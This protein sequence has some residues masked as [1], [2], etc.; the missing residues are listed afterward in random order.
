M[1][2]LI[3]GGGTMGRCIAAALPEH[4]IT[5]IEK[6]QD[7]CDRIM[8]ELNINVVNGD[9][10]KLYILKKAN[11][12]SADAVMAVTNN[13]DVNLF[14]SL[15]AIKRGKQAVARVHEPEYIPIFNELGIENIVS[16]EQRAA[17]DIAKKL[18][19]E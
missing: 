6:N 4:E 11:F 2:I 17:M 9:A 3:V 14:I 16:P 19:W 7:K 10:S 18:V 12:D 15:L 13:D 8:G 5:L 1:H